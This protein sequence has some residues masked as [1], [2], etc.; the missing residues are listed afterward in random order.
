MK[1]RIRII[2]LPQLQMHY[3]VMQVILVQTTKKIR[4]KK[5]KENG[6]VVRAEVEAKAVAEVE[7]GVEAEVTVAVGLRVVGK[8]QA[9]ELLSKM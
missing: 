3:L 6:V 5:E 8:V 2:I 4:K 7:A 9:I 1:Q